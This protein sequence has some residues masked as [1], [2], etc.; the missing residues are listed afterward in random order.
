MFSAETNEAWCGTDLNS[1]VK[2]L[3]DWVVHSKTVISWLNI[4]QLPAFYSI[5]DILL[6][7]GFIQKL[8]LISSTSSCQQ[9]FG[10]GSMNFLSRRPAPGFSQESNLASAAKDGNQCFLEGFSFLQESF[11]AANSFF[12]AKIFCSTISVSEIK[13]FCSVA[14]FCWIRS[15]SLP[16]MFILCSITLPN[17]KMICYTTWST[18]RYGKIC[19]FCI[20]TFFETP[21]LVS[22]SSD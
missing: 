17:G 9:S 5:S 1:F 12:I 11:R 19:R 14:L 13:V 6:M 18:A 15:A 8:C 20:L 4:R 21:M 10:S 7:G 3:R 2:A 16:K 22:P